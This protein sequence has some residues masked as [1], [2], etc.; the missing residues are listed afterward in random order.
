MI[1]KKD[2]RTNLKACGVAKEVYK[3]IETN[4]EYL[5][6]DNDHRV[7]LFTS[8]NSEEGKT[9]TI[10]NLG[11]SFAESDKKVIIVDCDLRKP[12][13][14]NHFNIPNNPG[15]TNV[16]INRLDYK[17]VV[18]SVTEY[19][20][21]SV[22]PAGELPPDPIKFLNSDTFV[23]LIEQLKKDYDYIFIDS[24]P[25]LTVAD[26][27]ILFKKVDGIVFIVA[28]GQTKKEDLRKAKKTLNLTKANLI[29]T[30]L[31]KTEISVNKYNQYYNYSA[32]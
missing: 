11:R 3:M 20:T 23:N 29:G 27:S 26:T 6:L 25:L 22:L 9:S 24:P 18:L 17:K 19:N 4:L 15:L 13:I 10:A 2:K 21:L 5:D 30:I 1:K 16:L 28:S 31:T 8:S 12:Q 14:Y 32:R 7:I